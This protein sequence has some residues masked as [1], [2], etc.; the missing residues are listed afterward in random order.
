MGKKT[1]GNGS[2][3]ISTHTCNIDRKCAENRLFCSGIV[4]PE[5][6][7]IFTK[8]GI[9]DERAD[10]FQFPSANKSLSANSN[11]LVTNELT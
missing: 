8:D 2:R 3:I 10:D 7:I 9:L 6:S 5:R 11:A 4:V 1:L